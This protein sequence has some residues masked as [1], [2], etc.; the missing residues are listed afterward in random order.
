MQ[1]MAQA[2]QKGFGKKPVFTRTGGT[3]PVM[4]TFTRLLKVPSYAG[5]YPGRC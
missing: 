4:A 2:I 3:I 5:R 1:A